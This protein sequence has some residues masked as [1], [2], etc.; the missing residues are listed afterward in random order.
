MTEVES[1]L[2]V[3]LIEAAL[4]LFA[5]RGYRD[6]T[7]RDIAD[8]A[9]V[10][11]GS[12]RYHFGSKDALYE[13]ALERFKPEAVGSF[14]P[15]IPDASQMTPEEAIALFR[16]FV[17]VLV[18]VKARIGESPKIA[19][20]YVEGEGELGGPP[21]PQFYRRVISPGHDA[22]RRL[23]SAI[24]PDITDDETLEILTFNVIGQA[25]FLRVGHGV[26][27]KRL[28]KRTLTKKTIDEIALLIAETALQGLQ[29]LRR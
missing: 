11:H 10:S 7:L 19:M 4:D 20:F 28:G 27:L 29:R 22:L 23:I 6:T 3:R 13:A 8:K 12:V 21:N 5:K 25:I 14:F 15:V 16:E 18:T 1:A 24:R 17:Q 2:K 9:G 26:L